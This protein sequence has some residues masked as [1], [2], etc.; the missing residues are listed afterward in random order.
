M[1]HFIIALSLSHAFLSIN[2]SLLLFFSLPF[3]H[4][5][6]FQLFA[7]LLL[8]ISFYFDFFH[9]PK[10]MLCLSAEGRG[11]KLRDS[12]ALFLLVCRL[13]LPLIA[14]LRLWRTLAYGQLVQCYRRKPKHSRKT[15]PNTI[16]S[17]T[18]PTWLPWDRTGRPT[19]WT[20]ACPTTPKVEFRCEGTGV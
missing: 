8:F 5:R 16:L 9:R 4:S 3:Q 1:G 13:T 12:K 7:L 20:V 19:A 11:F 6:H 10:K 14:K 15:W 2:I 17:T 18:D